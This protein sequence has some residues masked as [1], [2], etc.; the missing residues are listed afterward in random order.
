LARRGERRGGHGPEAHRLHGRTI[1]VARRHDATTPRCTSSL[2]R[3]PATWRRGVVERILELHGSGAPSRSDGA[4]DEPRWRH[5]PVSLSPPDLPQPSVHFA[6]PR[7]P[8]GRR[9]LKPPPPP[10]PPRQRPAPTAQILR[11]R[12]QA[13]RAPACVD[14]RRVLERQGTQPSMLVP[15]ELGA[16]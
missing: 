7:G 16:I 3:P 6:L 12:P 13:D 9:A 1:D 10:P 11:Q 8:V 2:D 14:T 4:T 15:I 5:V